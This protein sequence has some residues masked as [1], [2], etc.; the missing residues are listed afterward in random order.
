MQSSTAISETKMWNF[1]HKWT[2]RNTEWH[3]KHWVF[4]K[5]KNISYTLLF[6]PSQN[7]VWFE[8]AYTATCCPFLRL[9]L[10]PTF[11]LSLL[12]VCDGCLHVF[13]FIL[14]SIANSYT[15]GSHLHFYCILLFV[16]SLIQCN[17]WKEHLNILLV[18]GWMKLSLPSFQNQVWRIHVL[19]SRGGG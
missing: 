3:F 19:S 11:Y 5:K 14:C 2:S 16:F 13:F 4:K 18:L 9:W 1:L 8:L 17:I 7:A 10:P 15:L 12:S 6:C